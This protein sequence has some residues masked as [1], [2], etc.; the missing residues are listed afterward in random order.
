MTT[1]FQKFLRTLTVVRGTIG[2]MAPKLFCMDIGGVSHKATYTVR[3]LLSN[4]NGRPKKEFESTRG[5]GQVYFPFWIIYD[6]FDK[7]TDIA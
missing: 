2:Y 7:D 4:G 5:S 3:M 6:Q 1:L